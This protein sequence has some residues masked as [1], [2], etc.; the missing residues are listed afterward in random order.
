MQHAVALAKSVDHQHR[1]LVDVARRELHRVLRLAA[2]QQL[3][4]E[5][6]VPD[7]DLAPRRGLVLGPGVD[8]QE[9]A[10]PR[11]G[12]PVRQPLPELPPRRR[13]RVVPPTPQLFVHAFDP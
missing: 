1:G 10:G 8:D 7:H 5:D 11:L 12:E 2:D 6:A 4:D 9:A 13:H 3:D